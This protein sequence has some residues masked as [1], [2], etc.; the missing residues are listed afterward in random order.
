VSA[1][2]ERLFGGQPAVRADAP[3]RV[4]LIGEHT[5][6]NGGFVLPVAIPQ[7]TTVRLNPRPDRIA[8][9]VSALGRASYVVGEE[10]VTHTWLD[11]VQG[12]TYVLRSAGELGG[13]D[14]LIDSDVP[15]GAGLSSSAA[16]E[17][18]VGRALRTAFGLAI[19]DVELARAGQRAEN[20]FVG[21]PVGIMDQ[22][23]SSLADTGAALFLDT[24]TLVFERVPIPT[25][26]EL[27]VIHSGIE[28]Q[29]AGGE[30]ASRRAECYEGAERLGVRQL[31]DLGPADVDRIDGLPEPLRRRVRH[32][33]FENLRVFAAVDA[34][35]AGDGAALGALLVAAHHSLRDDFEV[36][37]PPID[38][39]VDIAC[40]TEGIYG[41]RLTGGG[42]GGAVVVI[43]RTGE[44]GRAAD[45]IARTYQARTGLEPRVV[46]PRPT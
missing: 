32:V 29:H 30:Y 26:V 34:L 44:G 7:R 4:N 17:I 37:L 2:F 16:L 18:A 25:G 21:A 1:A 27:L 10:S 33:V 42:F 24:R 3:G 39:L 35:R 40:A 23:A 20:D 38:A 45:E 28:H 15:V 9:I 46:V 6:Y 11:Y 41:A 14:V 19:D 22:M 13:F 12:M 36:S 8:D 5:D 43:A 31:R